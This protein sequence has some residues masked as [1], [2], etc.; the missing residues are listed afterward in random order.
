MDRVQAAA[1]GLTTRVRILHFPLHFFP[2]FF[3]EILSYSAGSIALEK[4]VRLA[5][6]FLFV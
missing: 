3:S 2:F 6:V 1:Y 5:Q 4:V